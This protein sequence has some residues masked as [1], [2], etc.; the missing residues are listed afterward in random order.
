MYRPF[1]DQ[2]GANRP[3]EPG[4]VETWRVL[5]SSTWTDI[6]PDV[7]PSSNGA[8]PNARRFP[9]GDHAGIVSFRSPGSNCSVLPASADTNEIFQ[10]LP[11]TPAI[12]AIR[13]P[14]R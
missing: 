14:S 12:K 7:A 4:S 5:I 13:F 3:S 10:R 6:V 9:S 2:K 1:G 11:G 8:P